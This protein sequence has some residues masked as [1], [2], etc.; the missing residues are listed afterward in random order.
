[1]ETAESPGEETRM[2]A[3][4]IPESFSHVVLVTGSRSWNDEKSMRETFND[5]WRDW[6]PKNVTRP[7]LISGHCAEGADAMAERLW[8]AA[9]FG[10]RTFP[11]AWSAH[12]KR[13][14]FQRNQE[15][16]DAAQVFRGAGAQVLCTAFLD[17]CRKP[18]CPQRDQAQLMPH[19]PGHFSHGTIHCRSRAR[20]AGIETTSVIH[21]SLPPF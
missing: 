1:M 7:V 5:A 4:M 6:G 21:P 8:R 13:A 20:A 15:M 9:G 10:I 11:A 19:T 3:E 17:L 2:I 14:G 12:G 18:A 16:V